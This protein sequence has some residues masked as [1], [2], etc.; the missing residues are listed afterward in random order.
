MPGGRADESGAVAIVAAAGFDKSAGWIQNPTM[1]KRL[2][3]LVAEGFEICSI[4]GYDHDAELNAKILY[5]F[6]NAGGQWRLRSEEFRVN[7]RE[8]EACAEFFIDYLHSEGS[9]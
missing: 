4:A 3:Y 6:R 9:S 8:S 1:F 5:R 2:C 7:A